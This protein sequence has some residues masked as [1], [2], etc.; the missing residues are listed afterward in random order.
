MQGIGTNIRRYLQKLR[1]PG[2]T[3]GAASG[4]LAALLWEAVSQAG[5]SSLDH[6][7]VG[8]YLMAV[9]ALVCLILVTSSL[10]RIEKLV[11]NRNYTRFITSKSAR[12]NLMTECIKNAKRSIY[13]LSDLSG[14]KETQLEEHVKYIDALNQ[15]L[16][17]IL[18]G[19]LIPLL[20]SCS[21]WI[22]IGLKRVCHFFC[23]W[24]SL[25]YNYFNKYK[26]LSSLQAVNTAVFEGY[27][28]GCIRHSWV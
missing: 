6:Q 15:V 4:I 8:F 22:R 16:G 11:E 3:A 25:L 19:Q 26:L 18:I 17:E 9:I 12:L 21:V 20:R 5:Q 14:T 28:E 13:I 27:T 2:F 7:I 23:L 1:T 10:M 24:S